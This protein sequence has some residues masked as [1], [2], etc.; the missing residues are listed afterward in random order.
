[1]KKLHLVAVHQNY[2]FVDHGHLWTSL[3]FKI[4]LLRLAYFIWPTLL[5]S[6]YISD[7][8]HIIN[9]SLGLQCLCEILEYFSTQAK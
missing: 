7:N 3:H 8:A 2:I 6:H 4:A 9:F 1:M 5:M